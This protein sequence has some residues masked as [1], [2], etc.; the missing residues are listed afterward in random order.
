MERGVGIVSFTLLENMKI[1]YKIQVIIQ[2]LNYAYALI[3]ILKYFL[4]RNYCISVC[5]YNVTDINI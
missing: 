5:V 1:W 4:S 3:L 2:L